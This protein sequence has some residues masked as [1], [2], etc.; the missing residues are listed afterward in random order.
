MVNKKDDEPKLI[1]INRMG[2]NWDNLIKYQ[3]LFSCKPDDIEEGDDWD[4]HP[5]SSGRIGLP[6]D[7]FDIDL[8]LEFSFINGEMDLVTIDKSNSHSF[9]D[10]MEGII[11][12]A[13]EDLTKLDY[14]PD[15]RLFFMFKEGLNHVKGK[16]YNRDIKY[17]IL[18][19]RKGEKNDD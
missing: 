15:N 18:Y 6:P 14:Y 5:A 2:V 12:L 4:V 11:A 8:V 3:L 7:D 16:L 19:D 1:F 17:K 9:Y 13:W 10:A